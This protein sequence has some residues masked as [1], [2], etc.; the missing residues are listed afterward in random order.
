[1][2]YSKECIVPTHYYKLLLR[3]RSGNLRKPIQEC[4]AGELKAVGFWFENADVIKGSTAPTL[5]A[6]FMV[7]VEEIEKIT[8]F[9]FFP[10]VP[11]EVKRHRAGTGG[12]LD[13]PETVPPKKGAAIAAPSPFC[14]ITRIR[15]PNP[16]GRIAA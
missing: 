11:A 8:G 15:I 13:L 2:G 5:G 9:T 1:M 14:R 4:S 10:D 6:E 3:T 7:S 12:L 16:R